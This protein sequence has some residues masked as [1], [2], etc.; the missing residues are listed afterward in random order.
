MQQFRLVFIR[1]SRK[2]LVEPYRESLYVSRVDM[3][4][5]IKP[6]GPS[7]KLMCETGPAA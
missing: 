4:L 6:V 1:R 2:H 5:L 3:K 7:T